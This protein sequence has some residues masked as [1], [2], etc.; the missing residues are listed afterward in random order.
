[1]SS[2]SSSPRVLKSPRGK[3]FYHAPESVDVNADELRS[4]LYA[5]SQVHASS[6]PQLKVVRRR[7][8]TSDVSLHAK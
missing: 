6:G 2:D 7:S 3:G 8:N 4:R 5:S 1:M